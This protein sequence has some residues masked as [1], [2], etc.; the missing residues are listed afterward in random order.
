MRLCGG[1]MRV[2]QASSLDH[3]NIVRPIP[4]TLDLPFPLHHATCAKG[5]VSVVIILP[6]VVFRDDQQSQNFCKGR[7]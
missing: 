3:P 4:V 7:A 2:L 5:D 6:D 1:E